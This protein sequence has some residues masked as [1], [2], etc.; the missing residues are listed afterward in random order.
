MKI[1]TLVCLVSTVLFL[2]SWGTSLAAPGDALFAAVAAGDKA[3]VEAAVTP[4]NANTADSYGKTLLL[5]AA[6]YRQPQ[7]VELLLAKGAD[8]D[9][10]NKNG[11]TPV[12]A[13][14]QMKQE[15]MLG[16]LLARGGD[17]DAA[18]AMGMTALHWAALMNRPAVA[19]LL[20]AGA[21][22]LIA[23]TA[24]L[25][26]K[27]RAI[28]ANAPA[29]TVALLTAAEARFAGR[30]T[31]PKPAPLPAEAGT[32]TADADAARVILGPA[33]APVTVIAYIDFE[34]PYSQFAMLQLEKALAAFPGKV[35]LLVKNN[36]LNFHARA[37][38]TAVAYELAWADGREQAWA[39]YH[40]TISGAR[41]LA[42]ELA[43]YP[44]AAGDVIYRD[45]DEA[46]SFGATGTPAFLIN[47]AP[48]LGARQASFFAATIAAA[49]E[50]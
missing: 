23:N 35:R 45:I 14:V 50:K 6:Q 32:V 7:I 1:R 37:F 29:E 21:N 30:Q 28:K 12:I 10:A 9:A 5:V 22:P 43:P 15:A 16:L 17:P 38:P 31:P 47:G 2:A 41:K 39:F 33:D 27:M 20:D 24:G 42:T 40:D 26:P 8:V 46:R 13:A 36:P 34:C 48:V 3:A 25:T 19:K 49:L 11:I 18:D 44:A 4:A